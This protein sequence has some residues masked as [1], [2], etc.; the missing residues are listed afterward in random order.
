[1]A[2]AKTAR[3]SRGRYTAAG[4]TA[5][6]RKEQKEEDQR[7]MYIASVP[8]GSR[9]DSLRDLNRVGYRSE[10]P[11]HET[12]TP[13]FEAEA[14][15]VQAPARTMARPKQPRRMTLTERLIAE[16]RREKKDV[17]VCAALIAVILMLTA[18]WGQKMVAGVDTQRR[19]AEYQSQTVAL[20]QENERLSQK[21]EQAKNGER[22]R[23]LAQNELNMLRPERAQ[24]ETI[25]IQVP[26]STAGGTV[27]QNEEPRMELLD[28]LLG[29]LNVFHIG[30]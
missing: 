11:W 8:A 28:I 27:Q 30:E 10:R 2:G 17:M 9:Q 5:F 29:L 3:S 16:A 13:V 7:P 26:D 4:Y 15:S 25:Y 14:A 12:P 21:L 22:I 20:Q 23:N 1:M 18:A 6:A 24:T 19:I